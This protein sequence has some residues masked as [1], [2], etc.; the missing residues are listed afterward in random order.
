MTDLKTIQEFVREKCNCEY[1]ECC[2]NCQGSG[3][4]TIGENKV[5]LD[6]AIDAGDRDLEGTHYSFDYRICPYC[7]GD[8]GFKKYYPLTLARILNAL[9]GNIFIDDADPENRLFINNNF[10]WEYINDDGTDCLF[11][12][13]PEKTQR[14]IAKILGWEEK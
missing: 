13:Q 12:Q 11:E 8:G 14:A 10:I 1:I 7:Q 6:M 3:K 2:N 4:E 5:T 9:A